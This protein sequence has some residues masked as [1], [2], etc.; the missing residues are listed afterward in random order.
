M[1]ELQRKTLLGFITQR[2]RVSLGRGGD[3]FVSTAK[4]C[5]DVGLNTRTLRRELDKAVIARQLSR[6]SDGA[7]RGYAYKPA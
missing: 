4:L 7:G 1:T 6:R 2:S 3:G 5:F